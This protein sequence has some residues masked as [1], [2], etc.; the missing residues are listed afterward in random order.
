MDSLKFDA[1]PDCTL[2]FVDVLYDE[3][4]ITKKS[5]R[6]APAPRCVV[7]KPRLPMVIMLAGEGPRHVLAKDANR[8]SWPEPAVI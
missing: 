2:A 5:P 4:K 1:S 3:S 7:G 8:V 6:L